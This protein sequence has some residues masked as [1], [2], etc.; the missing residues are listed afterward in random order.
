M[1]YWKNEGGFSAVLVAI[2]IV[3]VGVVGFAAWRVLADNDTPSSK[4]TDSSQQNDSNG[5]PTTPS[6]ETKYLVIKE[7]G[8]RIPLTD[9]VSGAYYRFRS[10][11]FVEYV[12]LYD[13]GFEGLK[14]A[15]GVS[16]ADKF[17]FYSISRV[18]PED[19]SKLDGPGYP[20]YKKVS[21]TDGWLY[22]GLGFHQAPPR[23]SDLN[24]DSGGTYSEDENIL[25]IA[26]KKEKAFDAAYEHLESAE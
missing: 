20:D 24:A 10:D 22:G 7:W 1:R 5:E 8:A 9:D 11:D 21:F 26:D 19:V 6:E 15:N 16:C 3:V 2:A 23:C 13:K 17:Q 12:D 14:N 25:S 4:T 18:K